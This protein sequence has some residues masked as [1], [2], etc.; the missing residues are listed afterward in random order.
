MQHILRHSGRQAAC[1]RITF[2]QRALLIPNFTA[3]ICCFSQLLLT[4][5]KLTMTLV[6]PSFFILGLIVAS[7]TANEA[8][9]LGMSTTI[10][11]ESGEAMDDDNNASTPFTVPPNITMISSISISTMNTTTITGTIRPSTK[12]DEKNPTTSASPF[13]GTPK[14]IVPTGSTFTTKEKEK[15]NTTKRP[16]QE[17]SSDSTGII[18]LFVII[19]VAL[20]F[21][22]AC[23]VARKRG[24]R[25]SVDFASRPDEI[26]IPLSAVE[27]ELPAD[28]VSQNGL[29]TFADTPTKEPEEPEEKPEAQEKAKADKSETEAGPNA[30]SAA[31]ATSDKPKEDVAAPVEPN[32]EEK[33][34]DEGAVSN[35]TSVE[36]LKETNEN[37][38]NNVDVSQQM[39]LVSSKL[40]WDIPL[41]SPV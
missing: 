22:V 5:N 14:P 29:H 37:N 33:T 40:F 30:E 38:S 36:S 41:D 10:T 1:Q 4:S 23:Y 17:A 16:P 8:S 24:R 11:T 9:T 25:Y 3:R 34:D 21:G 27:P 18:I 26:N 2:R 12:G 7:V 13:S 35:K 15:E 19:I 39:D 31:P 32:V 20:G 6:G 28:T